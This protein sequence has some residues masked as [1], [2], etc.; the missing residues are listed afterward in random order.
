MSKVIE[1][2]LPLFIET[3]KIKKRKHYLNLNKYR[4][5]DFRLSNELKHGMKRV[6]ADVCPKFKMT[7][8]RLEYEV[9]LMDRRKRDVS[10]VCTVIDK[11]QCDALVELGYIPDDNYTYL[12]D[13]RYMFGGINKENPRC[14]I[15]VIEVEED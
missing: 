3:G 12:K 5:W 9:F 14:V 2:S 1:Y 11:F 8:F 15:R 13:I 4:N 10:N 7:N 6:V